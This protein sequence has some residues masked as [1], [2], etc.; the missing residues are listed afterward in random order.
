VQG[1]SY[2]DKVLHL[3]WYAIVPTA[4]TSTKTG[5]DTQSPLQALSKSFDFT[6]GPNEW[7]VMTILTQTP[8]SALSAGG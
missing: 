2:G 1:S 6:V 4:S 3:I 7:L 5:M 8:K